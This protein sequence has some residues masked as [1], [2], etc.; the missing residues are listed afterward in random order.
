MLGILQAVAEGK[1]EAVRSLAHELENSKNPDIRRAR[2]VSS[3]LE[4]LN[5]LQVTPESVVN[6]TAQLI[7]AGLAN[8]DAYHLA[9]AEH[10]DVDVLVT[11]DDRF[12][13]KARRLQDITKVRVVDP[14]TLAR[15]LSS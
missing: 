1:V 12:L 7:S 4:V 3:W 13:S 5:P 8:L 10:L 2:V 11:T 6:Q 15:E 14:I 9:W